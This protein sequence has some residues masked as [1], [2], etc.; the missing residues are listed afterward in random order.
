[1]ALESE[2]EWINFWE[3][4]LSITDLLHWLQ[5][6]VSREPGSQASRSSLHQVSINKD[7]GAATLEYWT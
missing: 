7:P 6:A 2:I 4:M 5:S 1:M 3:V